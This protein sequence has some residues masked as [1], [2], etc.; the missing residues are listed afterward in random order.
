MATKMIKINIVIY[1]QKAKI[2]VDTDEIVTENAELPTKIHIISSPFKI[3]ID[4]KYDHNNIDQKLW[5]SSCANVSK[6]V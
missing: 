4:D 2:N 6:G 5:I 1:Q 3:Y